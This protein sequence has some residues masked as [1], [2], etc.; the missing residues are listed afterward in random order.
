[1]CSS[2]L[3][4]RKNGI[5]FS[6]SPPLLLN[7]REPGSQTSI[8]TSSRGA[9]SYHRYFTHNLTFSNK[10]R[11]PVLSQIQSSSPSPI[12]K[13][14][15]FYHRYKASDAPDPHCPSYSA[16]CRKVYPPSLKQ[17]KIML[18]RGGGRGN[19]LGQTEINGQAKWV[20]R[21]KHLCEH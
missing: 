16:P 9:Q 5:Q 12:Q 15:Q 18:I 20:K 14:T 3:S 7:R 13:G 11:I 21:G 8:P 4:Q 6:L 10:Q 1:M 19:V 2:L 17:E